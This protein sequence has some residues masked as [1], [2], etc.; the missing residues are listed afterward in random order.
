MNIDSINKQRISLKNYFLDRKFFVQKLNAL[1][2]NQEDLNEIDAFTLC[3]QTLSKGLRDVFA[4]EF[5]N[6]VEMWEIFLNLIYLM[7]INIIY[8]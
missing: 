1:F 7:K 6:M 2:D 4:M 8:I 3:R 5:N